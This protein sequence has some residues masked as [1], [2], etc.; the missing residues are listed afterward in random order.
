MATAYAGT[1]DWILIWTN[2][3]F[4]SKVI[5]KPGIRRHF[6]NEISSEAVDLPSTVPV[7]PAVLMSSTLPMNSRKAQSSIVE[8]AC[9]F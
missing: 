8:D 3:V 5:R 4:D 1:W 7:P 2:I 6:E 9:G